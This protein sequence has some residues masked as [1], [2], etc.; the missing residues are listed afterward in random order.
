MNSECRIVTIPIKTKGTR[1]LEVNRWT[2]TTYWVSSRQDVVAQLRPE[3]YELEPILLTVQNRNY[4]NINY[5]PTPELYR[6][7]QGVSVIRFRRIPL[8]NVPVNKGV[9]TLFSSND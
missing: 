7:F 4:S 9:E 2:V 1:H 3:L 8:I 6:V 5:V